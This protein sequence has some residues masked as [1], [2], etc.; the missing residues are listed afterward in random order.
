MVGLLA[1]PGTVARPYTH[2]LI[3]QFAQDCTV[4]PLGSTELVKLA[5]A[6]LR[7]QPPEAEQLQTLLAPLLCHP[8]A[9]DMDTLVLACTHFPLLKVQLQTV[10]GP[11]VQLVDSGQAIAR[12]VAY[13]L[14]MLGLASALD[15]ARKTIHQAL[16]TAGGSEVERLTPA[17]QT[18][19]MTSVEVLDVP[20]D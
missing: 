7:G 19:G 16:F 6:H 17:L 14:E 13:W 11:Q 20:N 2:D 10:L 18:F 1:T 4:I 9:P 5:E 15:P 3:R 12:R 8:R